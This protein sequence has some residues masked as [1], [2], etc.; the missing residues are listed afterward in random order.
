MPLPPRRPGAGRPS[1]APKPGPE[2]PSPTPKKPPIALL[3]GAG[4]GVLVLAVVLFIALG[5]KGEPPPTPVV[6]RPKAP[7][8]REPTVATFYQDLGRSRQLVVFADLG[9]P[10]DYALRDPSGREYKPEPASA[11]DHFLGEF[12]K[13]PAGF[14]F[15]FLPSAEAASLELSGPGGKTWTVYR[16][17]GPGAFKD[18][19][20]VSSYE[21]WNVTAK[22]APAADGGFELEIHARPGAEN[23]RPLEAKNLI[24]VTDEGDFLVP[25][26]KSANPPRCRYA[27]PKTARELRLQT[28]FRGTSP[29]YYLFRLAAA[30][31]ARPEPA[32]PD[33]D[34]PKPDPA[35]P[36][37]DLRAQF[38]AKLSDPLAALRWLAGQP[39]AD[40]RPVARPA[41]A[42]IVNDDLAAGLKAFQEGKA[43][44]VEKHLVRAALLAD[45][46]SPEFSKQLMRMLF[47]L[48][49]PRKALT[50]CAPCKGLG[51][52]ACGTCKSGLAQGPCPSCEAKGRVDCLLCDGGGTMDHH[53][54]K[55]RM[56]LTFSDFKLKVAAGVGTMH[57]QVLTYHMSPCSGGQF[58]LRTD[59]VNTCEH[60]NDPRVK[61]ATKNFS[62]SKPCNEAWKELKMYA[63]NG[64]SK[65]QVQGRGGQMVTL[66]T[67]QA[68]RFFTDYETCKSGS[69]PCDLCG[70]RKTETCAP[71]SG[72]GQAPLLCATCEGTSLK[73]CGTCKG[74]GDSAWVATLLPPTDA[75]DLARSLNDQAVSLR[76]W[77][78]ARAR[79]ASRR[80]DLAR[81]HEEAKKGLD[82]SAKLTPDFVDVLCP[83][84]KANGSD[85]EECWAAGRREYYE[86]TGMYERYAL[87]EKLARQLKEAGA[88][89][90]APAVS[91]VAAAEKPVPEGAP[92]PPPPPPPVPRVGPMVAIPKTVE[93]IL[94]K[95]DELHE[96]GKQ[97]LE[98]S[99][100][101]G[102][103][104]G[105]VEEAVLAVTDLKNAQTLYAT[106]Q[107]KLDEAGAPVPRELLQKFRTNMQALVMARKQ[108]P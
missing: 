29:E 74:Y 103:G 90:S 44:L 40:A 53:G 42:R 16:K 77:L 52:S 57:G 8:V 89:P 18:P 36:A 108:V 79:A 76:D 85:C 105:W 15:S 22:G 63:F 19:A 51:S 4:G 45:P 20:S 47:L 106:A 87:V 7:A 61:A 92:K 82:P 34:A 83:R 64:K 21:D 67:S 98:K 81:R 41:L 54:Y 30:E 58:N 23:P 101:L 6:E 68:R 66:R 43:D 48:R 28:L 11:A 17:P 97:H 107:E 27:V 75:S 35:K 33:A 88:P 69:L 94:Q 50:G 93:E 96:T 24:L 31:T 91:A 49:Q 60:K 100:S 12:R 84:C 59:V 5:G 39:A 99:K 73:A 55:G 71:C 32:K 2:G 62:G 46:Y 37:A 9:K 72:R 95:A 14:A 102:D 70:G 38:D 78:D 26:V 86:G 1:R 3:A 56:V 25:E 65:I 104:A 13:N 80:E 10:A